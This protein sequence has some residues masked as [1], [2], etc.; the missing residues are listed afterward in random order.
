MS[1]PP[2]TE[3]EPFDPAFIS[4]S[5]VGALAACGIAFKMHYVDRLPEET[6]GTAAL[7]GL[8]MHSAL[9]HWGVDRSQSLTTL[10]R[11]AWDRTTQDTPVQA[12]VR[13][14]APLSVEAQ[15]TKQRIV[16]KR[17]AD[18]IE[19]KVV[20][21]TKAWKESSIA[22]QVEQFTSSWLPKL[23]RSPWRFTERDPLTGL[24]DETLQLA[25][26]YETRW[27]H[28]R[29][30]LFA[31]QKFHFE[32][33]GFVLR[34]VIDAIEPLYDRTTDELLGLGL[35]DYKTYVKDPADLKDW[36]QLAIYRIAL[37]ELLLS[38]QIELPSWFILGQTPVYFGLDYV[39]LGYRDYKRLGPADTERLERELRNYRAI[40]EQ[41]LWMP[42]EKGRN[43]D[44]C[45]Y[46]S[47][48]CLRNCV[49]AGGQAVSV[50]LNL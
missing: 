45:G 13:A 34:G 21:M 23:E 32:W 38:G 17:A 20:T 12:F 8:V 41:E 2:Q 14:Y 11:Q 39:R 4:P 15:A 40:V 1:L 36:R 25:P 42:A 6:S 50:E 31:E 7:F 35:T 30:V 10:V 44:F 49:E 26:K 33:R 37:A 29:P 27:R 48:C 24:Y 9:E 47:R 28:L 19:T 5:R 46:P 18:G 16:D 3:R 22:R 43:P